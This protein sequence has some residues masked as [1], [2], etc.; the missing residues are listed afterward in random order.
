MAST[1]FWWNLARSSGV[2]SWVL[3]VASMLWGILL[4]TRMLRPY[5][6]PAWLLD[7]HRWFGALAVL[8]VGI[9]LFALHADSYVQFSIADLLFPFHS[10]WR[11]FAVVTG[12]IAMYMLVI[13]QLSSMLMKKLP[14]VVWRAIHLTSYVMF[15]LIAVHSILAGHDRKYIWFI[16]LAIGLISVVVVAT[17]LRLVFTREPTR[18]STR[19]P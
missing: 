3:V 4:A 15:V 17:S 1:H 16:V 13:V 10:R 19:L 8:G 14:K 18:K 6:R 7:L 12:V 11:P 2:V 9:H 5:D